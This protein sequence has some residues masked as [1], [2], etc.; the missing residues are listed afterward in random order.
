MLSP[1]A[2]AEG[3]RK[4]SI[5]TCNV[6]NF[7]YF[8]K[9]ED[10]FV[11]VP[12]SISSIPPNENFL[13]PLCRVKSCPPLAESRC[14]PP[15]RS[16]PCPRMTDLSFAQLERTPPTQCAS[17]VGSSTILRSHKDLPRPGEVA[18]NA[19]MCFFLSLISFVWQDGWWSRGRCKTEDIPWHMKRRKSVE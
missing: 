3:G 17:C 5:F 7:D 16:T 12:P 2:A 4:I 11:L 18:N 6:P 13:S 8:L 19:P 15:C 14:S 9:F 1:H 10:N